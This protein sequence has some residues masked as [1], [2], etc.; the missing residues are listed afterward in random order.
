[1]DAFPPRVLLFIDEIAVLLFPTLEKF[2]GLFPPST[3]AAV[4][5]GGVDRCSASM[6]RTTSSE[7]ARRWCRGWGDDGVEVARRRAI[8][9]SAAVCQST[10]GDRRRMRDM[11]G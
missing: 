5:F 8:Q 10:L 7:V 3:L 4:R 9:A 6:A 11:C 2:H 1:M